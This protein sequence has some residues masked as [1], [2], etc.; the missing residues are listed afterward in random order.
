M[1]KIFA[2]KKVLKNFI[3]T[4][5]SILLLL[6]ALRFFVLPI[7]SWNEKLNLEI[8]S[9]ID[10]FSTSVITAV[11]VGAFMYQLQKDEK[12]KLIE[13]TNSSPQI[14]DKLDKSRKECENWKFNG[15]LGRYTRYK[16]IPKLSKIASK[17]R[18][19]LKL[20]IILLNPE[21]D[22]L[23]SKYID[24]R[25][26]LSTEINW[27]KDFVRNEILATIIKAST[28]LKH[29][30][31]LEIEIYL[32]DFFTLSRMDISNTQAIITR[33]DPLIPSI[34]CY[35]DSYMYKHYKEE[36]QQVKR[37]S[38]KLIIKEEEQINEINEENIIQFI[39]HICPNLKLEKKDIQ[40][41]SNN[42]DGQKNPF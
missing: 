38:K 33:E 19:T 5:I 22:S 29:N 36:Y 40:T 3:I 26:S 10:K 39:T 24:F 4:I 20:E 2:N 23:L 25:N 34:I 12:R 32:K 9:F 28:T 18:E 8:I 15:G 17:K 11:I 7:N 6:A 31:F 30:Q 13:F 42:I 16:T 14:E 1:D 21:N 41:I 27:S 37:Q 35:N